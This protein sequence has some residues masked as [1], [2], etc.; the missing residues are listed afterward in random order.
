MNKRLL[1]LLFASFF[2]TNLIADPVPPAR[3]KDG[4]LVN[5]ILEA[6]WDPLTGKL[7]FPSNLGTF[8]G[9]F[10]T[11]PPV[12]LTLNLPVDDPNDYRIPSVGLNS[13][14]GWSTSEKWITNFVENLGGPTSAPILVPG[15]IDPTSVVPGQSVRVF[16]VTTLGYP[17][18]VVTGIVRELTPVAEFVAVAPGGGVLAIVPTTPLKEFTTYMA[19]LTND[20]RDANGNNATPATYYGLAKS[21]TPWVDENGQSTYPLLPDEQAP[22]VE[23]LRQITQS[24]ELNAASAGVNPDDIVLSWTVHTQS[25]SPVLKAMRSVAAPAD[26]TVAPSGLNTGAVGGLGLADIHIGVITVPFYSG[27]PSGENPI[28]P[29]TDFWKASPGALA[30]CQVRERVISRGCLG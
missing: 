14:D 16:E 13:L 26:S 17:Y 7:P 21:R 24:M 11:D 27:I 6:E 23:Q 22:L 25:I 8:P 15:D 3:N 19:V 1:I 4:S 30:P 12:D 28:A 2:V 5:G 29:L 10:P 9:L 20:I 18:I